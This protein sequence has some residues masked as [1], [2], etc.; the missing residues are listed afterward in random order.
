LVAAHDKALL[1]QQREAKRVALWSE[2]C[3]RS[4][5]ADVR[6]YARVCS[7]NG[8][9]KAATAA[10]TL[11]KYLSD[12]P[13]TE[14]GAGTDPTLLPDLMRYVHSGHTGELLVE[15]GGDSEPARLFLVG[16]RVIDAEFHHE[17]GRAAFKQL[18]ANTTTGICLG[19]VE[20]SARAEVITESTAA[21]VI[22][23]LEMLSGERRARRR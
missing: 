12:S 7:R 9:S 21:L 23:A 18:L 2:I 11:L 16:G 22:W 1:F 8:Y 17:R 14:N 20:M 5:A 10:R 15:V 4:T 3:Q 19:D 13:P 6:A